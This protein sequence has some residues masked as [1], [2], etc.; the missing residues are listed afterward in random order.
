M[1]N[2]MGLIVNFLKGIAIG[3]SFLVPGV[4]GGTMAIILGV[5]DDLIHSISAFFKEMKK[6]IIFLAQIGA[7]GVVGLLLFSKLISYALENFRF[8]MTYLFIGVILGGLPVLWKKC[9]DAGDNKWDFLYL[10]AGF[11]IV[12]VMTLEPSKIVDLANSTGIVN[13]LFLL[14][15]GFITAVALILP[16]IS[17]SFMLLTLGLY[18]ITLESINNLN[19]AFLA[20]LAI[21]CGIGVLATTKLLENL[22]QKHTRRTYLV[23]LGFVVGS[24]LQVFPGI[25]AGMDILYSLITLVAGF[26]AIRYISKYTS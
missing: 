22:M 25:P 17:T 26:I 16:G 15:A 10:V 8:P 14:L 5:Y 4:S 6:N 7:G 20:P 13:I 24:L 1:E 3:I 21:G 18:D 12:V 19:V 11:I 2:I 9:T 23:I